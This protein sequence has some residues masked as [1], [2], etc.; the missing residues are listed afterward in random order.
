MEHLIL[1]ATAEGLGSCWIGAFSEP[2]VRKLL[3]VPENLRI[4]ALTPLGVPNETPK[5]QPRKAL[6]DIVI[7]NKFD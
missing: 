7:N 6:K 1:A 2:D 4:V 5:P 3:N